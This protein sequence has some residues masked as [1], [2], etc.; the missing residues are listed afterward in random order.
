LV[1]YY[2]PQTLKQSPFTA[3]SYQYSRH[4]IDRK[5]RQAGESKPGPK[6]DRRGEARAGP[7]GPDCRP[8]RDS[9]ISKDF[10]KLIK[11]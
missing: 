7:L 4:C 5:G 6:I 8:L 9:P 11:T 3:Y 10:A 2:L 1:G